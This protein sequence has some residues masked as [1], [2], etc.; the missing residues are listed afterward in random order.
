M[1]TK[2]HTSRQVSFLTFGHDVYFKKNE[3]LLN[4]VK[5][6]RHFLEITKY[7]KNRRNIQKSG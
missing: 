6:V 3:S 4:P 7:D 1:E 5:F 2:I